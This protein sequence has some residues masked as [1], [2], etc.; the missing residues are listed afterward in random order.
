[1]LWVE[2]AGGV[3][4]I[5]YDAKHCLKLVKPQHLIARYAFRGLKAGALRRLK[6]R[7]DKYQHAEVIRQ[8]LFD[9]QTVP[10][11]FPVQK[12]RLRRI[13]LRT[14]QQAIKEKMNND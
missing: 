5:I 3:A 11:F 7:P 10:Q 14:I 8:Y 1:M 4:P 13:I 12:Q 2:L 9:M 6:E